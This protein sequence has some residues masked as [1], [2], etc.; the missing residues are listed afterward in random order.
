M[1]PRSHVNVSH[2]NVNLLRQN[3]MT[4]QGRRVE[5]AGGGGEGGREQT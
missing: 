5:E 3:K 1:N 2:D 4:Q